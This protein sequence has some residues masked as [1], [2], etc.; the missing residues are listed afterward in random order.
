MTAPASDPVPGGE[1]D[2]PVEAVIFDL[3][4]VVL[5]WDPRLAYA[6]VLP[7]D[8][9]DG[10]LAEIDFP[11]WNRLHDAGR[12]WADG[13]RELLERFPHRE[14]AVRAYRQ[15]FD[16]AIPGMVPGTA[17]VVAELQRRG[18]TLVALTNWAAD[19]FAATRPRFDVLDRFAGIVVSGTEKLAKPD[20]AIFRLLLDRYGLDPVT[21]VFVDDSA[22]NCAAARRLGLRTVTFTDAAALR[23]EL[24]A[25]GLVGAPPALDVDVHHLVERA[26]WEE[27]RV[28][29]RYPWSTRG[30]DYEQAGFVHTAFADQVEGVRARSFADVDPDDLLRVTLPAGTAP[31]LVEPAPASLTTGPDADPT[32]ARGFP[33][34]FAPLDPAGVS[35]VAPLG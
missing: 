18:T 4:G 32:A 24:A 9:I 17:A 15:H 25:L 31:I 19:T 1:P 26:V 7:E 28:I 12:P 21:T 29:G 2:A 27:A 16:H 33:H 13:E 20:P 35:V 22:A 5:R 11:A 3:G 10:F 14:E 8:E 23:R 6:R 34:L 30:L